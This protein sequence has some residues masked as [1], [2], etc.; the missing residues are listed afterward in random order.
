MNPIEMKPFT[1]PRVYPILDTESIEAHGMDVAQAASALLEGGA[2]VLQFRHKAEWR[3]ATF[4]TAKTVSRLCAEAGVAFIVN[5]RADFAMLLGA[6]L[7]VGQDDLAPA[8]ARKLLGEN[9]ILGFSTH[10][11][12]QFCDACR[13]PA[14]YLAVGPV[15]GTSSKR[16]PDPV[17]GLRTVAR[18]REFDRRPLVAIGGITLSNAADV[19]RAGADSVAIIAGLFPD[20]VNASSLRKR[21]EEWQQL[22]KAV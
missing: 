6:G 12:E 14:D 4:E 11:P 16:N 9:G 18:C 5:D 13:E 22:V 21:M 1:L 15:Y 7:H 20:I 8:D 10:N 19:L 2:R 17:A 3:R